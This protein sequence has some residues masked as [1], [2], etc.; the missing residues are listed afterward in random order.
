M[1]T[2][3]AFSNQIQNRNFLSPVGFKF[4]LAKNSKV[5]FF[6]NSA[7]IPDIILGTATGGLSGGMNFLKQIMD[8]KE[9]TLSP[10]NFI[11]STPNAIAGTIAQA[12]AEVLAGLVYVNSI[13]PGHP[14]IAGTWPFVSDLRTGAMSGGSGEQ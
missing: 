13:K 4:T 9:K 10:T 2:R 14:C 11:Q 6:C 5:S 7:R 3:N 8:Y 1:A 12:T